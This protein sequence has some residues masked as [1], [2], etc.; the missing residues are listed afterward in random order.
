VRRLQP[1]DAGRL[2]ALFDR[3]ADYALIVDGEPFSPTA[4]EDVFHSGPPGKAL[5]DKFVFGLVDVGGDI[6][7]LLE[8]MRDY[9]EEGIWW[10]GLLLL[11]PEVRGQGV[12]RKLVER[13]IE[14][15]R[16]QG[17]ESLMLGVVVQNRAARRFWEQVE[18]TW[19]RTTEPRPFGKKVQA[20]HVLSR[21][22]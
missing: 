12:G 22:L 21:P 14:Y 5:D 10:I 6:V 8:G 20:V 1:E 7:G 11:A 2:Q 3:C 9:P 17:A 15:A 16:S 19:V 4:G 18:F 13:F